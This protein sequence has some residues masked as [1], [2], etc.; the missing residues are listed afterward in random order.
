[1]NI[2]FFTS[3]NQDRARIAASM[4]REWIKRGLRASRG[5]V[6]HGMLT[7]EGTVRRERLVEIEAIWAEVCREDGIDLDRNPLRYL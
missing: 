3:W 7:G 4:R 6:G 5:V 1:M 2:P